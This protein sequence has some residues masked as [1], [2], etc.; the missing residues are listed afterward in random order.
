[1]NDPTI[2]LGEYLAGVQHEEKL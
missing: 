2:T 1:M